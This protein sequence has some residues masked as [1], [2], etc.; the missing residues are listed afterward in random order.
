[1][2]TCL[3]QPSC[4]DL[5]TKESRDNQKLLFKDKLTPAG[6][7]YTG[8]QALAISKAVNLLKENHS[9][10]YFIIS[11]GF[12]FV[13]ESDVLPPYECSFSNLKKS[14][15]KEMSKNLG[16]IPEIKNKINEKYD[17]IYLALGNDYFTAIG[18]IDFL[19]S[20]TSL[21]VHFNRYLPI[22]NPLFYINDSFIV[23]NVLKVQE[24][25]FNKPIGALV[26]SKG[27]LLENYALELS[28]KESTINEIPLTKWI[29]SKIGKIRQVI[30]S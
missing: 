11:A 8:Q 7:L 12:G 17:L 3:E 18:D 14:H 23:K 15:I 21:L 16:I 5:I 27:T 28:K 4:S 19:S 22:K 1:M 25:I 30:T 2:V 10:D 26:A 24:K 13:H 29:N 9:V 20:K 6:I